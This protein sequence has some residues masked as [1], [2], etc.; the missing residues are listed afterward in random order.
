MTFR[1]LRFGKGR[2]MPPFHADVAGAGRARG[3]AAF[4]LRRKGPSTSP[5][6][7]FNV[8]SRAA[9]VMGEVTP[10]TLAQQRG[11]GAGHQL[12]L[13]PATYPGGL[14]LQLE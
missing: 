2:R 3:Q 13:P 8:C 14:T 9:L 6:A 12:L 11:I 1:S 7:T 5:K 10:S 4:Q